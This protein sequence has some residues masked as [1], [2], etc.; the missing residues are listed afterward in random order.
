MVRRGDLLTSDVYMDGFKRGDIEVV[1]DGER[2]P[3]ACPNR[4]DPPTTRVNPLDMDLVQV[5]RSSVSLQSGLGGKIAYHRIPAGNA[6]LVQGGITGSTV[7]GQSFDAALSVE[8]KGRRLSAQMVRGRPYEDARGRSFTDRYGYGDQALRY[9]LLDVS[10]RSSARHIA[11]GLSYSTTDD[12]PYPYLQ[13]DE[14]FNRLWA[15]YLSYRGNKLYVNRTHHLMDNRFRSGAAAMVMQSDATNVTVGLVGKAYELYFRQWNIWNAFQPTKPAPWEGYEQHMIPRVSILAAST[16][17]SLTRGMFSLAGKLGV[18][19]VGTADR[20]RL[21]FFESL[22]PGA[23]G[24]RWFVPFGVSV[25][26]RHPV[27]GFDLGISGEVGSEAPGPEQLYI[28]V[29]KP[30]NKPAWSGAPNLDAPIK[31]GARAVAAHGG[32][33]AGLFIHRVWG[34]IY[35]VRAR[36]ADLNYVTY[37]NVDALMAGFTLRHETGLTDVLLSYTWAKN[38][39]LNAP[40]A[41]I[42]PIGVSATARTPE[43]AGLRCTLSG[44]AAAAQR[45]IDQFLGELRTPSWYRVDA[46]VSYRLQEFK[47]TAELLNLTNQLY[48]EHLSY[49]RDPFASGSRIYEPGRTLR[50][51]M[52]FNF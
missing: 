13:M 2:Y 6:F 34:Y 16:T 52:Q 33:T 43:A 18:H 7:S 17:H 27:A 25:G 44:R 12:V 45:R 5:E 38:L 15:G 22:Y 48:Y 24:A 19:R 1:I 42:A 3:S 20:D 39:H 26:V 30:M 36:T 28:S 50:L 47:I 23:S 10:F 40:L 4:M 21:Q 29:R 8:N 35:P 49:Q 31:L 14:R 41:D 37:D 32:M 51:G 11:Y 46:G 9:A